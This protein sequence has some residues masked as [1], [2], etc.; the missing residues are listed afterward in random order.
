MK[1]YDASGNELYDLGPNGISFLGVSVYPETWNPQHF[2]KHSS[3]TEG[4]TY[5][6][7]D[8]QSIW[9]NQYTCA[10]RTVNNVVEYYVNGS[11]Q[12]AASPNEGLYFEGQFN[13]PGNGYYV[14]D[15]VGWANNGS[16]KRA[17]VVYVSGYGTSSVTQQIGH[18]DLVNVDPDA[19]TTG[20]IDDIKWD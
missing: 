16:G 11:W 12:N 7:A 4:S 13:Y 20:T 1:F 18:I 9:L 19:G 10:R 15:S 2:W 3:L 17:T 5:R 6:Q 8:G 14:I